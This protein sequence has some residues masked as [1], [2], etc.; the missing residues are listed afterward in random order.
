MSSPPSEPFFENQEGYHQYRR[1]QGLPPIRPM[2]DFESVP[3][4]EEE[5][6][7][8]DRQDDSETQGKLYIAVVLFKY[9]HL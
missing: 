6:D 7:A 1:E 9:S 3:D 2:P 8:K 5:Q 4:S